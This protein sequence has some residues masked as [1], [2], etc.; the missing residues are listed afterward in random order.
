MA[1]RSVPHGATPFARA[2][3]RLAAIHSFFRYVVDAEPGLALLCQRVLA[4]PV[5]KAPR[6]VL[7]YLSDTELAHVLAQIDRTTHVGERDYLVV[8]LLYDTGRAFRSF[9][10]WLRAMSDSHCP[11]S[12]G[13]S[14]RAGANNSRPS[15]RRP[16][17]WCDG[18]SPRQDA[19]KM[20]R[21]H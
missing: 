2:T 14:A 6:P 8:A 16:L 1:H 9:W 18:S 5:K 7:G 13:Y 20:R 11:R 10:T 17:G 21:R 19:A 15:C 4:I 3:P 12:S